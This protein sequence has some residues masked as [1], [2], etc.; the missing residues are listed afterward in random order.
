MKVITKFVG[1]FLLA[2]V[3]SCSSDDETIENQYNLDDIQGKWY[4]S[5]SNN[6][7]SDGMEVT[8]SGNQGKVT[9]PAASNFPLNSIKWKDIIATDIKKYQHNELGSDGNYYEATMELGQDDTLRIS[10]GHGGA[11][12]MQKWVR[13][14]TEPEPEINECTPYDADSFT[15]STSG[16]WSEAN[17]TD[18]YPN[19]LPASTDPAGGYYI[20][21]VEAEESTPWIDIRVA[22]DAGAI[23]NGAGGPT[24]YTTRKVAFSAH[25]GISYNV[26]VSPFYNGSNFPENYTI[27]WEYVGIMDCFEYNNDFDEAKFIPKD[28]TLEAFANINNEGYAIQEEHQDYYKVILHQPAKL[29]VELQQSPSDNFIS[30]RMYKDSS[31]GGSIITDLTPISGNPNSAEPGSLYYKTSHNTLDPGVYYIE[32][33]ANTAFGHKTADLD[34]GEPFPDTWITPYKFKATAV[35]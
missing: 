31:P 19:L 16:T 10:V 33:K 9:N 8:V 7:S 32:I 30:I 23:I 3:V 15:N 21:T 22:G 20:V 12:N 26:E 1:L 17:E 24:G 27:T 35:Q 34:D 2:L 28:E 14:Y 25:P 13:T 18:L 11:G 4:R 29:K 6:P 5:Y